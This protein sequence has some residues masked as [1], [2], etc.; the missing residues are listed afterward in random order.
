M[1][2]VANTLSAATAV[3]FMLVNPTGALAQAEV[4]ELPL[5]LEM[6]NPCNPGELVTIKGTI[7]LLA[8]T[9]ADGAGGFHLKV[10]TVSKGQGVSLFD[11]Y[12]YS[13][14]EEFE[15][16]AGPSDTSVLSSVLNHLLTS[17]SATDNFYMKILLHITIANGE[18][19]PEV[20]GTTVD[21]RG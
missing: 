12:V 3:A 18:T 15:L 17:T 10:G 13:K 16:Y 2:R 14:E 8:Q 19:R 5:V 21:C 7:H 20:G 1:G 11:T 4:T 6:T 9:T